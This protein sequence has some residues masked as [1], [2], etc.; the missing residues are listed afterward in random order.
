V[1]VEDDFNGAEVAGTALQTV[2][3]RGKKGSVEGD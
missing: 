2:K 3:I 1:V